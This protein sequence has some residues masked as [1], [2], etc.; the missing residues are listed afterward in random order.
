MSLPRNED[1]SLQDLQ[2]EM[3]NLAYMKAAKAEEAKQDKEVA[4][5]LTTVQ[6]MCVIQQN[7]MQSML[8]KFDELNEKQLKL[9]NVQNEYA[10]S[11][12]KSVYNTIYSIYGSFCEEQKKAFR[13]IQKYLSNDTDEMIKKINHAANGARKSAEYAN[14]TADRIKSIENWKEL[15]FYFSPAVVIAD[16]IIRLISYF[17]G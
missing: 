12:Q 11:V 8:T 17:S 15:L 10:E 1:K 2:N 7:F 14:R 6:K 13:E 9:L 5:L 4:I 3:T 16:V